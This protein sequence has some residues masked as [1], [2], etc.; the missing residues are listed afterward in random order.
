MIDEFNIVNYAMACY[1][2]LLDANEM[3][4]SERQILQFVG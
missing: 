2:E 4:P 3:Q 1:N